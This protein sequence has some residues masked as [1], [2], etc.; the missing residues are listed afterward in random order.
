MFGDLIIEVCICVVICWNVL[1]IVL[2]VFKKDL[3]FGGYIGSFVLLVMF[4][5]V[6]F[7]Y[8]FKVFNEN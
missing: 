3:E 2:C 8:F 6:G 4:Y 5:D 7:N 1:M